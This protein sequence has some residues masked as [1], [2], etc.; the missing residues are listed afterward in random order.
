MSLSEHVGRRETPHPF[1]VISG[2]R[3]LGERLLLV[4][5]LAIIVLVTINLALII[6]DALFAIAPVGHAIG[7]ALAE[8]PRL[9][10]SRHTSE[11]HDH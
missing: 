5:D 2:D 7:S 9:V 3:S 10:R 8:R 6:F 11:F 4:W 1:A